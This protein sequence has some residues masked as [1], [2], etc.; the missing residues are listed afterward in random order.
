ME[1]T[2]TAFQGMRK[3]GA[4]SPAEVALAVKHARDS[5]E[6]IL[7]FDNATGRQ[8]EFDL[9]GSDAEIVARLEQSE[10]RRPGRPKLGV[11]ARE[12]TLLPRHWD[13]LAAQPG[14]A[15]VTLRK[16]VDAARNANGGRERTRQAQEASDRFM[17]VMAGNE[18]LYEE[19]ARAL[20]AGDYHSF[21]DLTEGW[22]QEVRDHARHLSEPA[23]GW[24]DTSDA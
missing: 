9:R 16:L 6:A 23:F 17:M 21:T 12:V 19:A 18:P 8:I 4:G 14:G 7:V 5:G 2:C 20:Y 10:P 15:S 3:I 11:T 13:W 24:P 22:P 1:M